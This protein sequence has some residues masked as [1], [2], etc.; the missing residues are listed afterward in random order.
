MTDQEKLDQARQQY[1]DLLTG[2]KA[3][4][5]VDSNGERVEYTAANAARLQR[6]I[7][8]LEAKINGT[9]HPGPLQVYF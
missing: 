1:H 5:F 2:L 6:Y 7:K 3:R 9:S 8:D 4:V